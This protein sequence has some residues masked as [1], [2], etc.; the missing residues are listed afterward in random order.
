MTKIFRG[1]TYQ[2]K[3]GR[4]YELWWASETVG[5]TVVKKNGAW[6]TIVVPQG[7]FLKTCDR[8][9]RGGYEEKITDAEAIELTAA[10]YGDYV[11]DV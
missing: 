4:R 6:T 9:L 3:L 1:P 11:F 5:K 10:G 2:K 8:V 7:D